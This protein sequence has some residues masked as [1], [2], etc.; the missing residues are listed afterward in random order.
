MVFFKFIEG[1][2]GILLI[3]SGI[4]AY[5]FPQLFV[6]GNEIAAELLMFSLFLSGLK[7]KVE[8]VFYLKEN[9]VRVIGL[10]LLYVVILPTL[11]ALTT[12]FI[13]METQLGIFLVIATSG[14]VMSPLLAS[15]YDLKILWTTA[16]VVLTGCLVPFSLPFLTQQLFSLD[17]D[18]SISGMIVFLAKMI[19]L[20]S[21]LAFAVRKCVPKL[22]EKIL[23]YAGGIGGLNMMLFL[24]ALVAANQVFIASNLYSL[25]TAYKLSLVF[26][27]FIGLY[28]IG[29]LLPSTDKQEKWTHALM[30]GNMNNGLVVL[31]S[32]EFFSSEVLFMTL[33]SIIPWAMAQPVFQ[34]VFSQKY[35]SK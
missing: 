20:P 24:S 15:F 7:I 27:V 13:P 17:V 34:F 32:K 12:R 22:V 23:P 3:L 1:N 26:S 18:I 9:I 29:Y 6:W 8:E 21:F 33:L 28:V 31:L 11:F 16:F 5:F 10:S 4:L 30:F 19:F 14:A 35:Q 25:E 2:F